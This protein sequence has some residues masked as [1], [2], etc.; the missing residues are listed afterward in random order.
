M[1]YANK[2]K[3]NSKPIKPKTKPIQTQNK[4]NFY[5]KSGKNCEFDAK[6]VK[7]SAGIFAFLLLADASI[8]GEATSIGSG[9]PV[10][11]VQL[12]WYILR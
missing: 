6:M 8:C 3:P 10:Q 5:K 1:N 2:N 12:L 4:P 11:T 9:P 7:I